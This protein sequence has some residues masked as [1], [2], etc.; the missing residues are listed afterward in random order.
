MDRVLH[1]EVLC[2][3]LGYDPS[4]LFRR[5]FCLAKNG[6]WFTFETSKVDT[7]LI[8]SMVTTLGTWK[9]RFF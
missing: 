6:N 4:L 9:Y 1:L 5:F 3:A 2:R 7:W 8:S